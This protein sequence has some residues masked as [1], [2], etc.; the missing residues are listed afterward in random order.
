MMRIP[1]LAGRSFSDADGMKAPGV[2]LV[3]ASTAPPL[4][5]E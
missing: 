2:V 3:S 1:L 5:A 4:L